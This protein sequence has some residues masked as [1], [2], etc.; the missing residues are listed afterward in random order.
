MTIQVTMYDT[1]TLLGLYREVPA[2]SNYFRNLFTSS[3]V[4][5]DNEYIDFE[6]IRG[7]RKLAPLVV[8]V[9]QGRPIYSEASSVTRLKPAYVKPKD[10]VSPA[11]VIKRRPGEILPAPNSLSPAARYN[12]LVGDILRDHRESIDRR[13]EWL[14]AR[15]II[16]GK[17]T[18][19]SPDYPTV[20]VDFG[21]AADQTITLGSGQYWSDVDH[22]IM[23]DVQTWIDKVFAAPF[24]GPV[25][26]LTV[27]SSVIGPMMKNKS[28]LA[29]LDTK[30]RGTNA[31]LNTGLRAGDYSQF[32]GMLGPNIELWVN[33]DFYEKPDG[34]TEK[35]LD[36][37]KVLLSGPN[38]MGVEAYGAI[39]DLDANLQ[40]LQVFPKMWKQQDP[41][42]LF[43]LTQSAPLFVP[44]NPNNTLTAQVLA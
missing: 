42:A 9:N 5:S 14:A 36:A 23:G 24:G 40:P 8:P 1:N 17:V 15:A 3:V 26:R 2:V 32:V 7:N 30:V 10:A 11:R 41:S 19:E 39:L 29:Q 44:V 12:A 20:V 6:K 28:V 22:D 35:F 27:G 38:V 43:I 25:N 37:K 34:T 16:D 21:R 13:I 4:V 18:L 31:N 33:S